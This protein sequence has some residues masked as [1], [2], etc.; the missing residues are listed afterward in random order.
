MHAPHQQLL[1]HTYTHI[2]MNT[3]FCTVQ[4]H[5]V[6]A[7]HSRRGVAESAETCQGERDGIAQRN[8]APGEKRW[9]AES[10]CTTSKLLSLVAHWR[11]VYMHSCMHSHAHA[12]IHIHTHAHMQSTHTKHYCYNYSIAIAAIIPCSGMH[13]LCWLSLCTGHSWCKALV[14]WKSSW[15]Q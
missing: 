1:T 11:Q 12:C 6:H 15:R 8:Q 7:G 13:S 14:H 9:T 10:F 4:L 5:L 2:Y 3:Y